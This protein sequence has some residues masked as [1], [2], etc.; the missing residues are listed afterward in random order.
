MRYPSATSLCG[1]SGLIGCAR[2]AVNEATEDDGIVVEGIDVRGD[3]RSTSE[4]IVFWSR[5]DVADIPY[6]R[7]RY[8]HMHN[9]SHVM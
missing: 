5:W 4:L 2:R 3:S 7:C 8:S 6:M 1:S 9:V